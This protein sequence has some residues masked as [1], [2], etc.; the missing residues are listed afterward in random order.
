MLKIGLNIFSTKNLQN[1]STCCCRVCYENY[2]ELGFA[3]NHKPA[4]AYE[5]GALKQNKKKNGEF[6]RGRVK[7]T[8]HLAIVQRLQI[9]KKKKIP[10]RVLTYS[11]ERRRERES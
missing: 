4:L 7:S 8:A 11:T 5:E 3:S 10:K 1:K 9:A 2:D 6:I